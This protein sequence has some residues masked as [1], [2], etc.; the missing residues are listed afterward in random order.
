VI[1]RLREL[2]RKGAPEYAPLDLTVLAAEVLG[3]VASD[4]TIRNMPIRLDLAKEPAPVRGDRVQIQQVVLNL[5]LNAMDAMAEVPAE[6]RLVLVTTTVTADE[7]AVHLAVRD[8]GPGLRLAD[9]ERVFEPFFTTKPAG[10]G[11]GL[12]IARSIVAAHGGRIWARDNAGPGAT[13][14]FSLPL[15]RRA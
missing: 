3:L 11:M 1:R 5:V 7:G 14:T 13:F 10:M 15:A 6:R 4:A 9:P 12:S 2:L 8:T